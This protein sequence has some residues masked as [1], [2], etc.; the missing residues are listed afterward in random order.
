MMDNE[1]NNE[2]NNI[3]DPSMIGDEEKKDGNG[4][5]KI[6]HDNGTSTQTEKPETKI[7]DG[8]WVRRSNSVYPS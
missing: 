8:N 4:R 1:I 5:E 6:R 2:D 7:V 3:E